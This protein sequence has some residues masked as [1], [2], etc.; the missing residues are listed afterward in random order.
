MPIDTAP[1]P[2]QLILY[3][4]LLDLADRDRERNRSA[5][6]LRRRYC[7]VDQ[8]EVSAAQPCAGCG[9]TC[10]TLVGGI[11]LHLTCPDP[12][13]GWQPPGP[14]TPPASETADSD[15][16]SAGADPAAAAA[17]RSAE[18][19]GR[20]PRAVRRARPPRRPPNGG[21]PRPQC[22]MPTGS[23]C[24]A[25][26]G[27]RCQTCRTPGSWPTSRPGSTSA[28]AAASS[29]RTPASCG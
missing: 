24:P 15:A 28:G 7:T 26:N 5:A 16:A 8:V 19:G 14:P 3:P 27:C 9:G 12:P 21:G 29:R 6:A 10:T 4:A 23:T 2:G 25:G 13:P 17:G 1:G 22:C 11:P 18:Q 20:V